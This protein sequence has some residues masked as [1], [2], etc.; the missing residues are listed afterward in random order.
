MATKGQAHFLSTCSTKSLP[1]GMC[2]SVLTSDRRAPGQHAL[3]VGHSTA[4][5]RLHQAGMVHVL[6]IGGTA[7]RGVRLTGMATVLCIGYS[8]YVRPYCVLHTADMQA[9]RHLWHILWRHTQPE[10]RTVTVQHCKAHGLAR[11]GMT[12]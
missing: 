2:A 1:N 3:C 8:V 12:V 9:H 6:C 5:G 11:V 7:C 4:C 10:Q